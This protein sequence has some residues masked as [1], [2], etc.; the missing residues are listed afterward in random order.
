VELF[1]FVESRQS[2]TRH[3]AISEDDV[4]DLDEVKPEIWDVEIKR[5][6]RFPP[7]PIRQRIEYPGTNSIIGC[8]RCEV[9]VDKNTFFYSKTILKKN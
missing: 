2:Y 4:F 5:P 8:D 1:T 9:L 6:P 7:N 3:A